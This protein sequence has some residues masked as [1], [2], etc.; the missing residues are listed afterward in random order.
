MSPIVEAIDLTQ[1]EAD[2]PGYPI[3]RDEEAFRDL[4]FGYHNEYMA[5]EIGYQFCRFYELSD[6]MPS[7]RADSLIL[8]DDYYKTMCH[9]LKYKTVSPHAM[10]LIYKS[11]FLR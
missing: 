1:N 10:F 4:L 2:A 7:Q 11:L 6:P 5:F 8:T 3:S 9:F